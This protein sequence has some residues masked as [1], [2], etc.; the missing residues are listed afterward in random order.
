MM[1]YSVQNTDRVFV[2][3]YGFLSFGKNMGKNI[4]KNLSK[5]L[6]GKYS[7]KPLDHAKKS[8]TDGL[9]T[10]SKRIIQKGAEGTSD[11]NGNEVVNKITK[12]SKNSQEN[13]SERVT[14]ENDKEIPKERYISSEER[15][16]ILDNLIFNIIA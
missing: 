11:L 15:L 9:K 13:N 5:I 2:K 12:V 10:S 14:N 16:K 1:P 8:V 6:S 4:G 7:L 3:D